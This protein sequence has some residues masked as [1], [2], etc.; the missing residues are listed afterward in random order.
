[1][2]G[3]GGESSGNSISRHVAGRKPSG[4]MLG[5]PKEGRKMKRF[6]KTVVRRRRAQAANV[7]AKKEVAAKAASSERRIKALTSLTA[8]LNVRRRVAKFRG[9]PLSAAE[10]A[11]RAAVLAAARN[12][13]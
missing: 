1:M 13:A 5:C 11:K 8:A 10:V 12:V 9:A 6:K 2:E 4:D 3:K 7:A